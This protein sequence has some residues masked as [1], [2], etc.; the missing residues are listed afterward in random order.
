M[1]KLLHKLQADFPQFT[2]V[3]GQAYCWSPQNNHIFYSLEQGASG[4][5]H[6]LGHALLGHGHY[7]SDIEL[8]HKEVEAWERAFDLGTTYKVQIDHAHAED[9]LDTYRDWLSKRSSCPSC[10][11]SGLQDTPERYQC[12]NCLHSWH[13]TAARFCRPYR[14]S[15]AI[16]KTGV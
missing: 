7:H 1:E 9:C 5:L 13:V 2:F 15:E 8:L 11:S 12:P 3:A 4:L 6:E 10:D 16:Q 14:R